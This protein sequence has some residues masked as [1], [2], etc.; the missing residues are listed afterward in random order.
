[1]ECRR[2]YRI[3]DTLFETVHHI[4]TTHVNPLGTLH[5]G[6]MLRWMVTTA[7]MTSMRV[8]R[9]Y[10]VLAGLDNVFFLAPLR[11]GENAVIHGW[12]DY[13]GNSSLEVTL[14]VEAEDPRSGRRRM[15]TVSHLTMVS[16]G[17]DLRPRSHG[18][19]INPASL[20]EEELFQQ[21]LRR[22]SSRPSKSVRERMALDLEEPRPLLGWA[23]A[24]T[25]H[26]VNPEDTIA[27]NV[28]H[29]GR[30]LYL[31]DE[32]AGIVAMKYAKGVT[33][34][35]A[36][37]ATSFYTPVMVGEVLRLD[38][39]LTY[40]GRS[41]MEIT[42]KA[43][44]ENPLEGVKRHTTTSHFTMVHIGADGRSK[45]VPSFRPEEEWQVDVLR[46]AEL[47]RRL[48]LERLRFVKER[49]SMVRPPS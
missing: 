26:L 25:H 6:V 42:I 43:V 3:K 30:L 35:G 36:V 17:E 31:M 9:G 10:T 11:L 14:L 1:M 23:R 37:D 22:R 49:L 18:V 41:S 45:P 8:V 44:K 48:R 28:M 21:A 38:A 29:A 32:L 4:T 33:V 40:V 13:A 39:A 46:E 12:V 19:C 15:T 34:T 5:G 2:V 16:V 24:S 20:D 47:R 7:T 27:Y